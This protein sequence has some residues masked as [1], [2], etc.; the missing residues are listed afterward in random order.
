[1]P[2][3]LH[4]KIKLVLLNIVLWVSLLTASAAYS[5]TTV[6]YQ[7]DF[8]GTISGWSDNSDDFA[9]AVT[10]FLGRFANG[11]TTTSRTFT[12][13]PNSDELRI[14][15]DLYRF[16]SWDNNTEFGFDRFEVDIDGVQLF[17]LPF[18]APQAARSGASGNIAW[19]HTPLTGREELGFS[20]GQFWFDQLHRFEIVI[21]NP[22]TSVGLALRADVTQPEFD[23]S[24]GYDN[25]LVTAG[26]PTNDIL[27]VAESFALIDGSVGG[28][29]ISVLTSDTING[30]ILDP[31]NVS[32]V[33]TAAS[34]PNVTLSPTT[35][36][37][38]VAP[39]TAAGTYTVDYEIC[40]LI[41]ITNCSSVTETVTVF[42][43]GGGGS[44]CP[45]GSAAIPGTYHVVS[46][47]V[48]PS[49]GGQPNNLN[50]AL[51]APLPEGTVV[52]N[53][54]NSGTTFFQ[55]LIYD[56]TGDSDI[57]VP[58]GEVI[59][60]SFASHYNSNPT[61][62]IS[63][64]LDG[65][66]YTSVGSSTGSWT[67]NTFR[68]D[69]YVVPSGGARFLEVSYGGSGGLRFDGVIYGTQCQ[70][71]ATPAPAN[72]NAAKTVS[73]YDPQGLG[74]Y[75]VPGNDVIYTISANNTGAGAV[76]AGSL[77]L[78]DN[79]PGDVSFFNG[80]IDGAG[81]ETD[82]VT[83]QETGSG[84]TF[85]FATNVGFSNSSAAPASFSDCTYTPAAGYD[86]NVAFICFNPSG[87]MAGGSNWAVSFRARIN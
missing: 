5:Q 12:V 11:Q 57:S 45:A 9:P 33:S 49:T 64:S 26:P 83:F 78:I 7:D 21:S 38:T 67:P 32:I 51:G 24:A 70:V 13:P 82:P 76:D 15:F 62:T 28:D 59:E 61:G 74:L 22:G 39:N 50:G 79:M 77:Q 42:V 23:E 75:A 30:A 86:P 52:H 81:P 14:A 10:R 87:S 56:L 6:I 25:F 31:N 80:D 68:Y 35:G 46:A 73:I 54:N 8:E 85:D 19:S 72:L 20:S 55:S 48:S 60:V 41:N 47:S 34:S 29:T 37:I 17:S 18:P 71:S 53:D 40:E 27:A 84:L 1:M 66:S 2:H 63:M 43:P 65:V 4:I 69:D 58:A 3:F 16:D 36:L 44:S